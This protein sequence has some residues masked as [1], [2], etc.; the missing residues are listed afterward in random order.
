MIEKLYRKAGQTILAAKQRLW[1]TED[2]RLVEDLNPAAR[3]LFC[4]PGQVITIPEA[5]KCGLYGGDEPQ[6]IIKP[7]LPETKPLEAETKPIW[8][9]EQRRGPGRPRKLI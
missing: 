1:L 3:R 8:P 4:H 5:E 7:E 2:G 6:P 9:A